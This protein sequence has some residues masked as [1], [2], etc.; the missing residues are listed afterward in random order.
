SSGG[1]AF[2]RGG[3]WR[4]GRGQQAPGEA[5]IDAFLADLPGDERGEQGA[6]HDRKDQAAVGGHFRD[7]HRRGQRR[8]HHAGEVSGHAQDA[9]NAD[10]HARQQRVQV[11]GKAGP[12]GEGGRKDAARNAAERRQRRGDELQRPKSQ[13]HGPAG[14]DGTGLR[15]AGAEDGAGRGEAAEGDGEAAGGGKNDRVAADVA[16]GA[17]GQ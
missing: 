11:V 8:L 2:G 7:D 10:R 17:A 16:E 13:G 5:V 15:I 3:R 4:G 9:E 12:D 6:D 1:G 14:E